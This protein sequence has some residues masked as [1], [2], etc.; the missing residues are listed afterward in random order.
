MPSQAIVRR[1]VPE[2]ASLVNELISDR[3]SRLL[4]AW[5]APGCTRPHS[6]QELEGPESRCHYPLGPIAA[7]LRAATWLAKK[8]ALGR[9][10]GTSP[11][12]RGG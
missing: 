9:A 5:Q 12:L 7:M 3:R 2:G 6:G 4:G 11:L 10:A 8:D 1:F